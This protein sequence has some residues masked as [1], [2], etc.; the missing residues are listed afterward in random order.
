MEILT[1]SKKHLKNFSFKEYLFNQHLNFKNIAIYNNAEKKETILVFE[2]V[3]TCK[4][5]SMKQLSF[6][7]Y[8]KLIENIDYN[9]CSEQA[10]FFNSF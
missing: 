10:N 2:N 5:I 1:N 6:K 3:S 4:I 9:C 7:E 8:N